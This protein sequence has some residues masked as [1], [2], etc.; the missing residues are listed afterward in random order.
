MNDLLDTSV[1][2]IF[3]AVS[4]FRWTCTDMQGSEKW[5]VSTMPS[6]FGPGTYLA[7]VITGIDAFWKQWAEIVPWRVDSNKCLP[8][9][10]QDARDDPEEKEQG[11]P[12]LQIIA[13]MAYAAVAL[14]YL[15]IMVVKKMPSLEY[16]AHTDAFYMMVNMVFVVA[17]PYINKVF[18]SGNRERGIQRILNVASTNLIFAN[19]IWSA[20][21]NGLKTFPQRVQ[22]VW[23]LGLITTEFILLVLLNL[24]ICRWSLSLVWAQCI[25]LFSSFLVKNV[26]A[27]AKE[28][29]EEFPRW[30]GKYRLRAPVPRTMNRL[31]ELDQA[32][33]LGLAGVSFLYSRRGTIAWISKEVRLGLG[34]LPVRVQRFLTERHLIEREI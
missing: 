11:N 33:A 28:D 25:P 1:L 21:F 34:K 3:L 32:F 29:T 31:T 17:Y 20:S 18:P 8:E 27:K 7:W 2:C 16:A 24:T 13:F 14:G 26:L 5:D 10:Q 30:S 9:I 6:L 15:G 22:C 4:I 12:V 19:S 23:S